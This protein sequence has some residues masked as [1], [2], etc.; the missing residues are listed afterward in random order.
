MPIPRISALTAALSA[1]REDFY[2][3]SQ[4]THQEKVN[5]SAAALLQ[6]LAKKVE[7]DQKDIDVIV[8]TFLS[9][10]NPEEQASVRARL[11]RLEP[12]HDIQ[13]LP[14]HDAQGNPIKL[15]LPPKT[16]LAII[17]LILSDE[18][19][20]ADGSSFE[21]R[22]QLLGAVIAAHEG[23]CNTGLRN[24]M[25][26]C[27]LGHDEVKDF[28]VITV[29][30]DFLVEIID[31]YF[32]DTL[33]L[34][35]LTNEGIQAVVM[36]WLETGE[37][38]PI[39]H[40]CID[41]KFSAGLKAF[42]GKAA[43][44]AGI[45]L[46]AKDLDLV[47]N[48]CQRDTLVE[49][50]WCFSHPWAIRLNAWYEIYGRGENEAYFA[51]ISEP[52]LAWLKTDFDISNIKHREQF[53]T[54]I[55]LSQVLDTLRTESAF[56]HLSSKIPAELLEALEGMRDP[57]Q[58]QLFLQDPTSPLTTQLA[59][60]KALHEQLFSF[61]G[62][63]E[64]YLA[65]WFRSRVGSAERG[66]LFNALR[67]SEVQEAIFLSN[68]ILDL[69]LRKLLP[70]FQEEGAAEVKL[71]WVNRFLLHACLVPVD[72]WT[73]LFYETFATMIDFINNHFNAPADS[74]LTALR[75]TS[76]PP[77]FRAQLNDL[78][79]NYRYI[80][81]PMVNPAPEQTEP[82]IA[83]STLTLVN[84]PMELLVAMYY[85]KM[86]NAVTSTHADYLSLLEKFRHI[87][88]AFFNPKHLI[89]A[90]RNGQTELVRILLEKDIPEQLF[91]AK[92]K[93]GESVLL[94]AAYKGYTDIVRLLLAK[95]TQGKLLADKDRDGDTV[96]I[97]AV[98]N[99]NIDIVRLLLES[100][101]D[102]Q[103]LLAVGD[104]SGENALMKA[105][106]QGYID[107]LRL[108]LEKDVDN[109]LLLAKGSYHATALTIAA[110]HGHVNIVKV[111]LEK[112]TDNQLLLAKDYDGD[113][114]LIT[115]AECGHI[116][117]V[118]LLLEQD[119]NKQLLLATGQYENS[120]LI[121]ASTHGYT[122]IVRLLLEKD[123]DNQ[124]LLSEDEDGDNALMVAAQRGY[125]DI[126]RLLIER[127]S[128]G[129]LLLT[130]DCNG[131]NALLIAAS[132]AH[133]DVV[134]IIIQKYAATPDLRKQLRM[135][136]FLAKAGCNKLLPLRSIIDDFW[137]VYDRCDCDDNSLIYLGLLFSAF[138][139]LIQSGSQDHFAER[140]K[141]L[142]D[143][144]SLIIPGESHHQ[145]QKSLSNLFAE[146]EIL[147]WEDLNMQ[148]KFVEDISPAIS[149]HLAERNFIETKINELN[150]LITEKAALPTMASETK[151]P[152]F[153]SAPN[154]VGEA[155]A[156]EIAGL[157]LLRGQL[158]LLTE[159]HNR[160]YYGPSRKLLV[161]EL[162]RITMLVQLHHPNIF[163]NKKY[164]HNPS[165]RGQSQL[166]VD[167]LLGGAEQLAGQTLT[168]K[169]ECYSDPL[170]SEEVPGERAPSSKRRCI[171]E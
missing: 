117:V 5:L 26:G 41:D 9:R 65:L 17:Y 20:W 161:L 86:D 36:P 96:L 98:D 90:V 159:G 42:I 154:S 82:N 31:A 40:P 35:A 49:W 156:A 30:L 79:V 61:K 12:E 27:V 137:K 102:S 33:A 50:R 136:D 2:G 15:H 128:T 92:D 118:R 23:G 107:I 63:I 73:T 43:Q 95:D 29:F 85:L 131:C 133:N 84:D 69:F 100:D 1:A 148:F 16:V 125:V 52:L 124:L 162:Q 153:D 119:I 93:Y 91:L 149:L 120:A 141:D 106:A 55:E 64:N 155:A 18:A 81:A 110:E 4:N 70:Q 134:R 139:E 114:A 143:M 48:Y 54:L 46:R 89:F 140:L 103:L 77:K 72:Q 56:L 171:G 122:E 67:R 157:E 74:R 3:H 127:D 152:F 8:E 164:G 130:I 34:D 129:Q 113:N 132:N 39:L 62:L 51:A 166:F 11:E 109:Q 75:E 37:L 94:L 170:F 160:N 19:G 165:V 76:Y 44:I 115:A 57:G 7:L 167:G 6:R 88:L 66:R 123:T 163:S 138:E 116:D 121:V 78:L 38:P 145:W 105:A 111:L 68:E 150:R 126:I 147:T 135:G 101:T 21:N 22:V 59:R 146:I 99:G 151:F 28:K 112:D 142:V 58:I 47:N 83:F 14:E 24:G 80:R 10:V 25:V 71:Y 53:D 87:D 60:F 45:A 104:Y 169:R 108:L 32:R 144:M 168:T 13:V 158:V 97:G